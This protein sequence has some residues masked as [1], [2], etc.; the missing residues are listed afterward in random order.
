MQ[1]GP[2]STDRELNRLDA[3][4]KNQSDGIPSAKLNQNTNDQNK[5][6]NNKSK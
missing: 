4:S 3:M 2:L 5:V 6:I 1:P